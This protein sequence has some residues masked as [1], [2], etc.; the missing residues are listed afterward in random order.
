MWP[1]GPRPL[2]SRSSP[3]SFYLKIND[4]IPSNPSGSLQTGFCALS[5]RPNLPKPFP[6]EACS[7]EHLNI[8]VPALSVAPAP[9]TQLPPLSFP[10]FSHSS[11]LPQGHCSSFLLLSTAFHLLLFPPDPLPCPRQQNTAANSNCPPGHIQ[12]LE[13]SLQNSCPWKKPAEWRCW[14][15][16]DRPAPFHLLTWP[17][18]GP[19]RGGDTA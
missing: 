13:S 4:P 18:P 7:S 19:P 1:H 16:G 12:E 5:Q 6:C 11:L 3:D 8:K 2:M 17:L 9:P 14:H 15:G 10:L